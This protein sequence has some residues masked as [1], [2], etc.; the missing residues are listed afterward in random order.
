MKTL[1]PCEGC[2]EPVEFDED[3]AA[4]EGYDPD[5]CFIM[6]PTCLARDDIPFPE[7]ET[8]EKCSTT[9]T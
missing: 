6:C 4:A 1:V 2:G 9:P 7:E 8:D 5:H 3:E